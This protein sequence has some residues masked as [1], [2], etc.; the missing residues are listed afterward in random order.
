MDAWEAIE[1]SRLGV[2]KAVGH[3]VLKL[4]FNKSLKQRIACPS[5]NKL[6]VTGAK[7]VRACPYEGLHEITNTYDNANQLVG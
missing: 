5:I 1:N 6:S 7:Y 4:F 2:L 3:W